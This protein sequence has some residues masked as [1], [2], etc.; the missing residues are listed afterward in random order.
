LDFLKL[1]LPSEGT[2][3]HRKR[4][5]LMKIC[6]F[7]TLLMMVSNGEKR[8]DYMLKDVS[9]I[10][11][12]GGCEVFA[13]GC[14]T[15]K[16]LGKQKVMVH[17]DNSGNYFYDENSNLISSFEIELDVEKLSQFFKNWIILMDSIQKKADYFS[18]RN[19]VVLF[20]FS[21]QDR[22][23][24]ISRYENQGGYQLDPII[25]SVEAFVATCQK[26]KTQDVMPYKP[27]FSPKNQTEQ[28]LGDSAERENVVLQFNDMNGLFGGRIIVVTGT[29]N[30]LVQ[31]IA[32]RQEQNKM[33]EQ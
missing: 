13:E 22:K 27:L 25:E 3:N 16:P 14:I 8:T 10:K 6:L 1:K 30:V 33:W 15:F 19:A 23:V 26:I 4:A 32:H 18:T 9:Q 21:L 29:G 28:F 7:I 11:I 17:V 12:S 20:D 2:K 24:R 5:K 31:V